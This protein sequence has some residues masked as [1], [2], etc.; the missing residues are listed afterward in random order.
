MHLPLP[1]PKN[2]SQELVLRTLSQKGIKNLSLYRLRKGVPYRCGPILFTLFS[3][4]EKKIFPL[5]QNWGIRISSESLKF[6]IPST[7]WANVDQETWWFIQQPWNT[8]SKLQEYIPIIQQTLPLLKHLSVWNEWIMTANMTSL[9]AYSP[10]WIMTVWWR[11]IWNKEGK[12]YIGRRLSIS[13][14]HISIHFPCS[15]NS[16]FI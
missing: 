1:P 7:S 12:K 11:L 3:L 14:A 10:F 4:C 5:Y 9:V 16:A 15:P 6:W 13:Q 8:F 2:K